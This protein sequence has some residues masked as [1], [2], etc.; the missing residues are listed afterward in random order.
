MQVSLLQIHQRS[1]LAWTI[2]R[3]HPMGG[4]LQQA[5]LGILTLTE[6]TTVKFKVVFLKKYLTKGLLKLP[7]TLH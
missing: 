3:K 2:P 5:E 1:T 7:T 4:R 6:T